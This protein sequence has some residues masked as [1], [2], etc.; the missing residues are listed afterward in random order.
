[1]IEEYLKNNNIKYDLDMMHTLYVNSYKD[2]ECDVSKISPLPIVK[3]LLT[4]EILKK[5]ALKLI[6]L[7][8][9]AKK[10]E[11]IIYPIIQMFPEVYSEVERCLKQEVNL[12]QSKCILSQSEIKEWKIQCPKGARNFLYEKRNS[13][14]LFDFCR[15]VAPKELR[16]SNCKKIKKILSTC[17]QHFAPK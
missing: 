14:D 4:S 15:K 2:E 10:F 11:E 17:P 12:L 9:T 8:K 3:C 6:E 1:M 5:D 16:D 13:P 7:F